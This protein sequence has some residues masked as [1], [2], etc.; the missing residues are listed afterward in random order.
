MRVLATIALLALALV[1]STADRAFCAFCPTYTCYSSDVCGH[2][3][4]CLG[5]DGPYGA[6][7]CT[8]VR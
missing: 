1:A 4:L 2:G 5:E 3:C 8:M 7:T 6:G